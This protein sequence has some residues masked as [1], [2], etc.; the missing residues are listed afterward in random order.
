MDCKCKD[1]VVNV[2]F[3][4]E[5][6]G[7]GNKVQD[8][9]Y[10]NYNDACF[11]IRTKKDIVIYPNESA[12]IPTGLYVALPDGYE[13]QIRPRSG[14]SAKTSLIFKNTIGTIDAGY[15]NEIF[16]IWYNLGVDPYTFHKGDRVAQ[17]KVEKVPTVCFNEIDSLDELKKIG[18]DRGGGLGHTGLQ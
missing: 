1:N 14:L 10:A 12:L 2:S 8:L 16:V 7:K 3:F 9:K 15:R 13:L 5:T 18:F 4:V 6:D 17:G 11:D